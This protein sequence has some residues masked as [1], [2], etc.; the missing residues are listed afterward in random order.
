MTIDSKTLLQTIAAAA[1]DKKA[2][3]IILLDVRGLASFTDVL[4]VASGSSDRQVRAIGEHIEHQV[5]TQGGPRLVGREGY[6]QGRWVL[7]DFG[8]IVVHLFSDP[9]R[10]HFDLEHLWAEAPRLRWDPKQPPKILFA[11]EE[12]AFVRAAAA[13]GGRRSRAH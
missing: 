13:A 11:P 3:N 8:E 2:E 7:V 9:E 12:R 5:A 4:I 1:A 6:E 10:E